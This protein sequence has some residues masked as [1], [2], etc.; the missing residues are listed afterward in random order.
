[1]TERK[2][3]GRPKGSVID[4]P[5]SEALPRIRV[6]PGQLESYNKAAQAGEKSLSA[7]VRD[8]LDQAAGKF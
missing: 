2:K 1:M 8:C 6:K 7:W 4:N 3:R 5:A